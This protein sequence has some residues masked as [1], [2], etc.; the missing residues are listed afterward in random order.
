MA[1]HREGAPTPP[2]PL[3]FRLAALVVIVAGLRAAGPI[4]IPMLLAGFLAVLSYPLLAA[5]KASWARRKRA[6]R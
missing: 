4:L 2:S 1:G 3:L 5:L 6:R